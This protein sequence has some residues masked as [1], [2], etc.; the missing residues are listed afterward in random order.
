MKNSIKQEK[1][2]SVVIPV[3]NEELT[4]FEEKSFKKCLKVLNNHPI[5]IITS[6]SLK[7]N[8][9]TY[10]DNNIQI[11]RF[12]PH[13]FSGIEGYCKLMLS[14][15]FYKQFTDYKYVLI[16]QLDCYVFNDDLEYWCNR[17]YD[18]MGAP[19]IEDDTKYL[20]EEIQDMLP[21]WARNHFLRR[22]ILRNKC[23]VGNGGAP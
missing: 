5:T 23:A 1:L 6:D 18:Y 21:R 12:A 17:G 8:N 15:D 16:Y 3:Y 10:D 14:S 9:Y 7:L 22:L 19:W 11:V 2:V 13:Y 4:S 20:Y